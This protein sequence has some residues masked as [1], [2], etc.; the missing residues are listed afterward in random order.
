MKLAR[1][2]RS[3][4]DLEKQT[5][6][7]WPNARTLAE[8]SHQATAGAFSEPTDSNKIHTSAQK[9]YEPDHDY[10]NGLQIAVGENSGLPSAIPSA[11][12]ALSS[13]FIVHPSGRRTF[14]CSLTTARGVLPLNLLPSVEALW[15]THT[16]FSLVPPSLFIYWAGYFLE[17]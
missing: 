3:A 5:P 17:N 15:E 6:T 4:Q 8:N 7:F 13:M 1:W 11:R 10:S 16:L 12:A 2:D 9:S 14:L